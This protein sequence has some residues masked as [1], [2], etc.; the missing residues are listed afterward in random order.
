MARNEFRKSQGVVP[1]G[2][3]A[4]VDFENESLMSAGLDVWPSENAEGAAWLKIMEATQIADSGCPHTPNLI[5][6]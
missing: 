3:G 4:T 5:L 2:V 1:F 6:L